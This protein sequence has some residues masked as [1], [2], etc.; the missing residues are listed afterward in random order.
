M[1]AKSRNEDGSNFTWNVDPKAGNKNNLDAETVK[2]TPLTPSPLSLVPQ[3]LNI[4]AHTWS[5]FV[6]R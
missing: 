3:I 5:D 6:Y 4:P 2:S 1:T